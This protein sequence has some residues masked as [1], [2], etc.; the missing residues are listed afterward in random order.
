MYHAK[1]LRQKEKQEELLSRKN[2][3]SSFYNG[4]YL[5]WKNPV[6]TR[7]HVPLHWRYDLNPETN[8]FFMERLGVNAVFNAGAI[9]LDGKY[10]LV[11]RVEG[12]D[13]KSFFA[14]AESEN[15]IDN[16]RFRE[17][18]IVLP[19]FVDGKYVFYTRPMDGFIETGSGG[20][21]GFGLADDI[22]NAVIEEERMTACGSIIPSPNPKTVLVLSRSKQKRAGCIWRTACGIQQQDFAMCCMCSLPTCT[23]RGR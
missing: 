2:E 21:I 8:P 4:I 7:D 5:R 16:F 11:V 14:V 12:N 1:Y 9:Y 23:S 17:K 3:K 18:P 15:G 6:L 10:C 22:T 20:G 13:R 19:K